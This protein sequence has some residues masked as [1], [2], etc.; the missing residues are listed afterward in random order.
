MLDVVAKM[1]Q[2]PKLIEDVMRAFGDDATLD[3]T[4]S[5]IA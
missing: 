2:K 4:R 5:A 1:A 3:L